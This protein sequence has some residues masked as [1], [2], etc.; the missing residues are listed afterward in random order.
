MK[1]IIQLTSI[2]FLLA[3]FAAQ[4]TVTF[5]LTNK[6]SQSIMITGYANENAFTF[7][8]QTLENTKRLSPNEVFSLDVDNGELILIIDG[9]NKHCRYE[10]SPS[11]N[12]KDKI[13][14][15]DGSQLLP[16]SEKH[17]LMGPIKTKTTIKNNVSMGELVQTEGM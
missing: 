12:N 14:V 8:H 5:L 1:R 13:L 11:A 17:H 4:A 9:N 10:T 7:N 16:A 15:W 6:G 2:M 3:G